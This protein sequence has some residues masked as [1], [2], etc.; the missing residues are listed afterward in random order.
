M[1]PELIKAYIRIKDTTPA[2]IADDLDVSRSAV[3]HV[4]NGKSK[5]ARIRAHIARITGKPE[6]ELWPADAKPYPGLR[7][8]VLPKVQRD[9]FGFPVNAVSIGSENHLSRR[10]RKA[11]V[12]AA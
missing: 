1:H 12:A 8:R 10:G 4:I 11:K 3:A 6:R 7:R 2:A 5:S 9:K